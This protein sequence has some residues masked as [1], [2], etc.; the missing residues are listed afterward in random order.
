MII[1]S[2]VVTMCAMIIAIPLGIACA[3]LLAEV[4]S[5]SV[6]T[7]LRPQL[8]FWLAYLLWSMA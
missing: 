6:R 5:H 1:G 4:A 7:I 8:S 2:V 3:I